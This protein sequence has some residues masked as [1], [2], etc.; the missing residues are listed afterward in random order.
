MYICTLPQEHS[1]RNLD[2]HFERCVPNDPVVIF[3]DTRKVKA[4]ID[5]DNAGEFFPGPRYT[6]SVQMLNN[7][8]FELPIIMQRVYTPALY[9]GRHRTCALL[10]RK[11]Y[12]APYLT[13]RGMAESIK[14]I[15][16]ATNISTQFNLDNIPYPVM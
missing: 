1:L 9:Q 2:N 7:G 16:G 11:E 8:E 3:L 4:I 12:V 6:N 10:A 15:A 5:K 14:V 13:A